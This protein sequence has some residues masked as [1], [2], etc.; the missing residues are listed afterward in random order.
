VYPQ[1]AKTWLAL[2]SGLEQAKQTEKAITAYQKAAEIGAKT[3]IG[4]QATQR[5]KALSGGK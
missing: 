2:A 5:I 3:P 1:S 4:E